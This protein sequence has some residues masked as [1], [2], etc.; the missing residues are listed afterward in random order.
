MSWED[1][2]KVSP[3]EREIAE[4][5]A[6]K[7]MEDFN[8]IGKLIKL[9]EESP[10]KLIINAADRIHEQRESGYYD[11]FENGTEAY[12]HAIDMNGK[13]HGM[14]DG[15]IKDLKALRKQGR[16]Q[17]RNKVEPKRNYEERREQRQ[18]VFGQPY[19]PR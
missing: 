1:I 19:P 15:Y 8:E 5:Y 6:P 16:S 9:M 11:Q 12:E 2:I 3:L 18:E 13:L 17:E 4:E 10:M 14:F 7:D